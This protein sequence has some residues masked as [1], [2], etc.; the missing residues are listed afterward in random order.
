[1][2]QFLLG[3]SHSQV[4]RNAVS[5]T[6][7]MSSMYGHSE[8]EFVQSLHDSDLTSRMP[9]KFFQAYHS[10][11]PR[12]EQF[13]QRAFVYRMFLFQLMDP[14]IND[15]LPL[16]LENGKQFLKTLKKVCYWP[17]AS[18]KNFQNEIIF[19]CTQVQHTEK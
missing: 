5:V 17:L 15:M 12:Q 18:N 14:Y 1:M 6:Y 13:Y 9:Q 2:F 10:L 16:V 19:A 7:D 4:I 11:V 8:I 3:S